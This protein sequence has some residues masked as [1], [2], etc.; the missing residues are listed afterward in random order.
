MVVSMAK[1]V[2]HIRMT[3]LPDLTGINVIADSMRVSQCSLTQCN[4]RGNKLNVESA[5]L[6]A[7][8]AT[9]KRVMLFGITHD[10][11]GASFR[12]EGLTPPDAVLIANDISVG[13]SMTTIE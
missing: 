4:V 1:D 10:Q 2:G 11:T 6:L 8:V 9:E 3:T 13:R 7:K 5:K 12:G